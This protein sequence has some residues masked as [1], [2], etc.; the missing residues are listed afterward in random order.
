MEVEKKLNEDT[1]EK[2]DKIISTKV[3][4]SEKDEKKSELTSNTAEGT[5]PPVK[6]VNESDKNKPNENNAVPKPSPK[7]TKEDI[8]KLKLLVADD[9]D[10]DDVPG[11]FFDDF[12][13]EDF[14]AG[15][16][17]VDDDD[18]DEEKSKKMHESRLTNKTQ[19]EKPVEI[20]TPQNK[21]DIVKKRELRR[22]PEKTKRAIEKDKASKILSEKVK[23]SQ[24]GLVPPGMEMEMDIPEMKIDSPLQTKKEELSKAS[25][26]KSFVKSTSIN[27]STSKDVNSST[28]KDGSL[29]PKKLNKI[30]VSV[31]HSTL[32]SRSPSRRSRS[33]KPMHRT[34]RRLVSPRKRSRSPRKRSRSPRKRSRSP[35]K[36]LSPRKRS[37]SPISAYAPRS[38]RRRSKSPLYRGDK[39]L[40]R[41]RNSRSRS[42]PRKRRRSR[43]RSRSLSRKHAEKKSFLQ[44]IAE[45][46]NETRPVNVVYQPPLPTGYPNVTNSVGPVEAG[47]PPH[48]S[49]PPPAVFTNVR[50]PVV[51]PQ[52]PPQLSTQYPTPVRYERY[53]Q[54]FFIGG[55]QVPSNV[56]NSFNI[57]MLN[58]PPPVNNIPVP[59]MRDNLL[60]PTNILMSTPN[61]PSFQEPSNN[62][63]DIQKLFEE[64]KISLTD[65][66][67]VTA[68]PEVY[69]A[70]PEN[71]KEKIKV[72]RRC[73][74]AIEYLEQSE[75]K[76]SGPLLIQRKA[77]SSS[78]PQ[79]FQSPLVKS[80]QLK[81][82]F[83]E[84]PTPAQ[85]KIAFSEY[86]QKLMDQVGLTEEVIVIDDHSF[87]DDETSTQNKSSPPPAPMVSPHKTHPVEITKSNNY[88]KNRLQKLVQ[89]EPST[90]KSCDERKK[91][92]VKSVGVQTVSS[93]SFSFSISTQVR[94]EDFYDAIPRNQSLASLTP[95][96]LLG[97]SS[98]RGP[99]LDNIPPRPA[100]YPYFDQRNL[101]LNR[102]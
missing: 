15:L 44:E 79:Q 3:P 98:G 53:D 76:F 90:C 28:S 102:W 75:K 25:Q 86:I 27:S 82:P 63:G 1:G 65:F 45:K 100:G 8:N 22:D 5:E 11:D 74:D 47:K 99:E 71:L 101:N 20:K 56:A 7:K 89:T 96:Q 9:D 42:Q 85:Q 46:L 17:I 72:I 39:R 81:V 40:E 77:K 31:E 6:K 68:K 52:V 60:E 92:L 50:P 18:W 67:A 43:S 66:L 21:N 73:Q 95:A 37:R 38:Q 32:S 93:A 69:A 59:P 70:S 62:Q 35:R 48:M 29:F 36:R 64:K 34:F 24:T 91:R 83:T 33:P 16:D 55:A 87:S 30:P 78:N 19:K 97:R 23:L 12:L 49:V 88:V 54:N 2:S 26:E 4:N 84:I 61:P 58:T 41:N 13:K 80:Y 10:D 94:E 57:P 51:F 14:M